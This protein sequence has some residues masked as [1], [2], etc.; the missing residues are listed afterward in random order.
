M[1]HIFTSYSRRDSEIVDR[2]VNAI[3]QAG[4]EVWLDREDIM[5]GNSWRVQ[6]VKAI[7]ACDAFILMLSENSAVSVN[8]HKEVILAQDSGKTIFILML[9]PVKVPAEI[10]YPLAGLQFIDLKMLGFDAAVNQLLSALKAHLKKIRPAGDES[11]KQVELVIQGVD[12]NSFTPEKQQQLLAFISTLTGANQSRLSIANMTAGSVHIFVDMDADAAFQLKTLALNSDPRFKEM[13]IAW[14]KITSD[15]HYVHI[16]QGTLAP[17]AVASPFAAFFSSV[18]GK[19]A[20]F[21]AFLVLIGLGFALFSGR[22]SAAPPVTETPTGSLPAESVPAKATATSSPTVAAPT[23]TFTPEPA[24][25]PS[26]VPVVYQVLKGKV[27]NDRSACRYGPGDYYLDNET[28]RRD[29]KLEVLG[30]DV[31]S[32]WGYVQADG[33][34]EPCWVDFKNIELDG[35][36]ASL[37]PVY[38]GKVS[39]PLSFIWQPPTNIETARTADGGTINIYW[40]GGDHPLADGDLESPDSPRFLLELWLCRDGKLTFTPVFVWETSASVKDKAGCSEPSSGVLYLIEKHGY[41][42]PLEIPWT[43]HP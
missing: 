37:E 17:A 2:V 29:I 8:V 34:K 1:S 41:T 42:G 18:I 5:A 7:D 30:R 33:Y 27:A 12:L 24:F 6:I 35:G 10:R 19:A 23:D 20:I 3:G 25:T 39:L 28:L 4:V 14:L 15:K 26:A 32:G 11:H 21:L 16:A 13:G 36:I 40:E 43:P 22:N 38:P 9:E 31:N